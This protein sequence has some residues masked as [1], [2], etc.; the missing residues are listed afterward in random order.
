MKVAL[1]MATG[2]TLRIALE[3]YGSMKGLF[4]L[5]F[6]LCFWGSVIVGLV[7]R[8]LQKKLYCTWCG[9]K[10]VKF[11]GG[12]EGRWIWHYRNKDGSQDK[13]VKDNYQQAG[14]TSA[15]KCRLCTA[16]TQG[17]HYVDKKPSKKVK[18]WQIAL[19]NE[20]NGERTSK[21]WESS[22]ATS[23]GKG[24]HKKTDD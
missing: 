13:R 2:V 24:A 4:Q 22:T 21:D 10:K 7:K 15:W 9:S 23:Y 6:G 8:I 11:I 16:V 19:R 3:E 18:I 5:L 17:R 14:Y 20:G 12:E 1:K